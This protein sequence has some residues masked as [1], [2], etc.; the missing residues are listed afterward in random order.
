MQGLGPSWGSKL[1]GQGG[2][3]TLDQSCLKPMKVKGLQGRGV[4]HLLE[5][6]SCPAGTGKWV[7]WLHSLR[8]VQQPSLPSSLPFGIYSYSH[9][10]NLPQASS[11]T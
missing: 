4:G 10:A 9:W 7:S 3:S 6:D 1:L 11:C 5:A 8:G 2:G